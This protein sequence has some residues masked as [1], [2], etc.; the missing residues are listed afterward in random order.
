MTSIMENKKRR[1][2]SDE[3]L[4]TAIQA[5]VV[6]RATQT[7]AQIL[8]DQSAQADKNKAHDG[9]VAASTNAVQVTEDAETNTLLS[10]AL[11]IGEKL[12]KH[13]EFVEG[14][15][16]TV[17]A[18][19][20]S[21]Y[22]SIATLA[23]LEQFLTD[24]ELAWLP[25]P[26][27]TKAEAIAKRPQGSNKPLVWDVVTNKK[28]QVTFYKQLLAST[29]DG[30][31]ELNRLK[32]AEEDEAR[33]KINAETAQY[34][35]DERVTMVKRS[36]KRLDRMLEALKKAAKI[37]IQIEKFKQIKKLKLEWIR[38]EYKGKEETPAGA[39]LTRLVV[40]GKGPI[41]K[42]TLPL[43]ITDAK[44]ERHRKS[45]EEFLRWKLDDAIK[46][47]GADKV[48][49]GQIQ[50]LS[51]RKKAGPNKGK[52]GTPPAQAAKEAE[53][54]KRFEQRDV[55]DVKRAVDAALVWYLGANPTEQQAHDL[56][57][58][59]A[60]NTSDAFN[61]SFYQLY[62]I[63]RVKY[64]TDAELVKKADAFLKA[65]RKVEAA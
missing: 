16:Q 2:V 59:K 4:A 6:S 43:R 63:L 50:A 13:K 25:V 12:S 28:P 29:P 57:I 51:G 8:A 5:P 10:H 24:E 27:S 56:A 39:D 18:G 54:E 48:T 37:M 32:H 21:D 33:A 52:D 65:S 55:V 35:S 41:T 60:L 53:A 40:V 38:D 36:N 58:T 7:T 3:A 19:E 20:W 45:V 17:E 26:G 11:A 23:W 14:M 15:K 62:M 49:L 44:D 42:S 61:A 64:E 9:F 47:H 30:K 1:A 34:T 46:L 22:K 31:K